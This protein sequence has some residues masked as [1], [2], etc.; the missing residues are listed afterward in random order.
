MVAKASVPRNLHMFHVTNALYRPTAF[1][2]Q[3]VRFDERPCSYE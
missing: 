1:H 2:Y 3:V